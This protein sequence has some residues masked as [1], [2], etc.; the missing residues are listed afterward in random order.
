MVFALVGDSTM[1]SEPF[2]FVDPAVAAVSSASVSAPSAES[3]MTSTTGAARFFPPRFL[4]AGAGAGMGF[5]SAVAFFFTGFFLA[6][7]DQPFIINGLG[8]GRGEASSPTCTAP[9]KGDQILGHLRRRLL[10]RLN[11]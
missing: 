11:L 9:R 7:T 4:G 2:P 1:T 10:V 3:S 5:S 6:A 8:D